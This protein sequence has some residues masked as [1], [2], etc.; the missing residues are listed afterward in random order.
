[1][2]ESTEDLY[3]GDAE[4]LLV[5]ARRQLELHG[6]K[7][8]TVLSD[9]D[10]LRLLNEARAYV[11]RNFVVTKEDEEV[12]FPHN[13]YE[14]GEVVGLVPRKLVLILAE[15]YHSI[16]NMM[17]DRWLQLNAEGPDLF[18]QTELPES[19]IVQ[20][21][22][23]REIA[24]DSSIRVKEYVRVALALEKETVAADIQNVNTLNPELLQGALHIN[25]DADSASN[26]IISGV[27]NRLLRIFN[28]P[29][30]HIV[31]SMKEWRNWSH[32]I[33][34]ATEADVPDIHALYGNVLMP[35][36]RLLKLDPRYASQTEFRS[37]ADDVRNH[38]AMFK[39]LKQ[40]GSDDEVLEGLNAGRIAILREEPQDDQPEKPGELLGFYNVISDPE[41]V[42]N[43]M[44][45]ELHFSRNQKYESTAELPRFMNV[46]E[47]TGE[48]K[49]ISYSDE[50]GALR[51]FNAA[52]NGTLS[53]SVDHAVRMNGPEKLQRYA[54]V[55][56]ALK[57]Q[58]YQHQERNAGK[59]IVLMK[60]ATVV[61]ADSS[62][63]AAELGIQPVDLSE[64]KQHGGSCPWNVDQ[65]GMVILPR[66]IVNVGSTMLNGRLGAHEVF[67][68]TEEFERDGVKVR[69]LWRYLAQP[70]PPDIP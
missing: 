19:E 69:I 37:V 21:L 27:Q 18:H 55:G 42:R 11:D 47:P 54:M 61:G 25:C 34:T 60:I 46:E 48:K 62:G 40:N 14:S 16:R 26:E 30:V 22:L 58:N 45:A 3:N 13:D 53:W 43:H 10:L 59:S 15:L 12:R 41:I 63:A 56:T 68:V 36:E 52:T 44:K 57:I 4:H 70:L 64:W 8:N 5:E 24:S 65:S 28:T 7:L 49:T 9:T 6:K 2:S 38:G 35:K 66:A 39:A 32:L 33:G 1:M 51:V 20:E 31:R 17:A 67:T 23:P 29:P 50:A